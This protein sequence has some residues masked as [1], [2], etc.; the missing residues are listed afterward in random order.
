V[1]V[2][3]VSTP[4]AT[5][6]TS[7]SGS[8][9]AAPARP[10]ASAE[11]LAL[12]ARHTD[13][14]V[15]VTDAE[16][17]VEWINDALSRMT[18]WTIDDLRGIAPAELLSG[19]ETNAVT[20]ET[21]VRTLESGQTYRGEILNY[22]R[23]GSTLWLDVNITPV[24]GDGGRRSH[25]VS[26]LRDVTVK[27]AAAQRMVELSTAVEA[28]MDGIAVVDGLQR[29]RFA[30]DAFARLFGYDRG[31]ALWGKTW[32]H[33]YDRA[34]LRRFESDVWPLL[35]AKQRWTGEVQARRRDG[36]TYP[37]ELSLTLL[38]GASVVL[39]ARDISDRKATEEALRLMSLSD[40]LTGLNN[41]RGLRTLAE[42]QL[43]LARRSTELCLLFF[44]DLD[45]FKEINDQ[46]GHH[47]GDQALREF[48]D[49]LRGTFRASD[50]LSRI[51]GD[52]FVVL[53]TECEEG[54]EQRLLERLESRL[55]ALNGRFG[56]DYRLSASCGVSRFT[57]GS[58][59]TLDQLLRE[60]DAQLYE[61][62]SRRRPGIEVR[63][64]RSPVEGD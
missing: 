41:R 40:P 22:R 62:K 57:A 21:I 35:L 20:A 44:L 10:P 36:S 37:Q 42:Q 15:I 54:Q 26:I 19:P 11:L 56:R 27:R 9:P 1:S 53:A 32:R 64:S 47:A 38:V 61:Q 60:A 7:D 49:A 5:A 25:S 34:Q 3:P 13:D 28:A 63:G 31:S 50:V 46:H 58:P 8:A 43:R 55:T 29:F 4:E 33:L 16:G 52:E 18:G 12:V 6:P 14:G 48:A 45:D 17:K 30:N 59:R 24:L 39:V 2:P 23:D 51:G